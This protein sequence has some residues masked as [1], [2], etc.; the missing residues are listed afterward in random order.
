MIRKLLFFIFLLGITWAGWLLY[1]PPPQ[2]RAGKGY[3][4]AASGGQLGNQMFHFA[5]A[6][7]YGLDH[8]LEPTYP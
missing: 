3:I 7:A 8:D 4:S 6:Y 1:N 5:T 2:K